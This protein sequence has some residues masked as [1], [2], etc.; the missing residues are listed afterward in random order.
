MKSTSVL[1]GSLIQKQSQATDLPSNVHSYFAFLFPLSIYLYS[2]PQPL[3]S[4]LTHP[5]PTSH[6]LF[7]L[8]SPHL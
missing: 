6:N 8:P 1:L 7:P 3:S 4:A 5:F 2:P